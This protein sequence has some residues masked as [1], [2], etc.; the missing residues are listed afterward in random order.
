MQT[1]IEAAKKRNINTNI[2]LPLHHNICL[3]LTLIYMW[4]VNEISFGIFIMPVHDSPS[5]AQE[6]QRF[7][8]L[9]KKVA[10]GS[11]LHQV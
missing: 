10:P 2:R 9:G 8:I 5:T 1:A 11:S 3:I 6:Q 7:I 4:L